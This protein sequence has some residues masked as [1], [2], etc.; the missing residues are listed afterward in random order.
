MPRQR[1]SPIQEPN[2]TGRVDDTMGLAQ[3]GG[4]MVPAY[5]PN[6]KSVE[7]LKLPQVLLNMIEHVYIYVFKSDLTRLDPCCVD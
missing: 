4:W 5:Q 7:T 2:F 3:L 1:T 6:I